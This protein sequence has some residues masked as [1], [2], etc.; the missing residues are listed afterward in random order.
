M[1]GADGLMESR[2]PADIDHWF[3]VRDGLPRPNWNEIRSWIKQ[4]HTDDS[5]Q[6]HA[7]DE[8]ELEWLNRL[9][10][11]LG[12]DFLVHA[13]KKFRLLCS[14][15]YQEASR[16]LGFLEETQ[17]NISKVLGS[18]ARPEYSKKY[19]VM[20]LKD[21]KQYYRYIND[22]YPDGK[23]TLSVAV[24]IP[25]GCGHVVLPMCKYA[26]DW[27]SLIHELVHQSLAHLPLPRW[28]NEG[29]AVTIERRA[30]GLWSLLSL[31]SEKAQSHKDWW[32][33]GRIQDFWAG[34]SFNCVESFSLSYELGEILVE[35]LRKFRAFREFITKASYENAG[36]D[37]AK[38]IL[39]RSLGDVA[40][41][42][43]G[44]G[45]WAPQPELWFR[46]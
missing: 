42:V 3:E 16:M 18:A 20:V 41:D 27:D 15:S 8:F 44:P 14:L 28:L 25:Q 21:I 30:N 35:R 39:G 43:L 13:S 26:G 2:L 4:H 5:W 17:R 45:S 11:A 37:A 29:I 12:E 22:F 23:H 38:A 6:C 19:A 36:E 34:K 40:A 9:G 7:W 46:D 1:A 33:E 24:F 10:E 32:N 31:T